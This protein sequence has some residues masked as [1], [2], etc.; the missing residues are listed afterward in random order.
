MHPICS[1][2]KPGDSGAP[3]ACAALSY[4]LSKGTAG[5]ELETSLP[6]CQLTDV[7]PGESSSEIDQPL[8]LIHALAKLRSALVGYVYPLAAVFHSRP[9]M[10]VSDTHKNDIYLVG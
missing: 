4:L 9:T 8:Y 7:L 5:V 2:G 10:S 1:D 6:V 3:P